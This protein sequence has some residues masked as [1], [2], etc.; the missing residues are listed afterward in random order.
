MKPKLT[1][2]KTNH[3]SAKQSNLTSLSS[4]CIK[5]KRASHPKAESKESLDSFNFL[6]NLQISKEHFTKSDSVFK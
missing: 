6:N 3:H 5:I 1:K 4:S 2:S